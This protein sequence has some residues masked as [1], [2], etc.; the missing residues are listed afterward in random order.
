M[1]RQAVYSL[2]SRAG[3]FDKKEGI[4]KNY[5]GQPK[6]EL[7]KLIRMEF[8]LPEDDKR[9]PHFTLNAMQLLKRAR[10]LLKNPYCQPRE[11]EK[12]KIKS[13]LRQLETLIEK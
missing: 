6:E 13:L 9:L 4:V 2:A 7:L 8:P 11:E 10:D 1:P 12:Q 3:S 5:T